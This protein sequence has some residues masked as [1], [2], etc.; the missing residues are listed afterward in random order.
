MALIRTQCFFKELTKDVVEKNSKI[1]EAVYENIELF[2]SVTVTH[3]VLRDH[4][5]FSVNF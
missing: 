3:L 1:T 4:Q 5:I 2:A